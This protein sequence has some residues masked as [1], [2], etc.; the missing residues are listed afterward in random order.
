M[1]KFMMVGVLG[2]A[3]ALVACGS[4]SSGTDTGTSGSASVSLPMESAIASFGEVM[5]LGSDDE[6]AGCTCNVDE[7][8]CD[9]PCPTS[10]SFSVTLA[11]SSFTFTYSDCMASD[12][13]EFNGTVTG[14]GF[15]ESGSTGSMTFDMDT[16][17]SCTNFSGTVTVQTDSQDGSGS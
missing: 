6:T 8:Q 7:T 14:S 13:S 4:S 12:G 17:G 9:C 3:V 5:P 16:F 10:G 15:E 2:M 11:G 1:K